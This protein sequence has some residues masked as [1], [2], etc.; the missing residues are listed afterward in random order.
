MPRCDLGDWAS[1]F[2]GSEDQWDGR[3]VVNKVAFVVLH[4]FCHGFAVFVVAF[5]VSCLEAFDLVKEPSL[6]G[7]C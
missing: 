2:F 3:N 4:W 5:L 6:R 1:L 7:L